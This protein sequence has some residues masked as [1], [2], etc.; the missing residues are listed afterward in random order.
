MNNTEQRLVFINAINWKMQFACVMY[1]KTHICCVTGVSVMDHSEKM[2]TKT[3]SLNQ[4]YASS[5]SVR[6]NIS[7]TA[8]LF[9]PYTHSPL[10][11]THLQV[12]LLWK[13]EKKKKTRIKEGETKGEDN[14]QLVSW[15]VLQ[16]YPCHRQEVTHN[17]GQTERYQGFPKGN[18][19]LQDTGSP[20][21][22][23]PPSP[24]PLV[25]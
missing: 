11:H 17:I 3:I 15:E 10:S 23:G 14:C 25:Q 7:H 16:S 6:C 21:G 9:L 5:L 19:R 2:S 18:P 4:Q 12:S 22:P 8:S 13:K 24:Y 20:R 1:G